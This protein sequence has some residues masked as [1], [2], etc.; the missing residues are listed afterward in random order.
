MRRRW[1]KVLVITVAVLA[2]LFVAA[3]RVAVHYADQEAA[4][5]AAGKYGYGNSSD[6]HLDVDIDGFPFLTQAM[7]GRLDH[8]T[9]TADRFYLD[10]TTN[11]QG[12][13][14]D[15]DHLRLDLRGVEVTSLAA[16][17]AEA[18][19]A[20]GTLT[21]SYQELSD[22]VTRLA[23]AG[24]RLTVSRAPGSAGQAARIRVTGTAGGQALDATGTLL[25]QGTELTL[26]V[27]G[28]RRAATSWSLPLPFGVGFTAARA[29]DDGVEISLVGHLVTLGSSRFTR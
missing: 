2:V 9:L 15:V 12:G 25:A 3:D 1:V 7:A 16:R 22:V 14:L 13:Y 23:G 4:K 18:N 8:V 26:T 5:L 10:N 11:R 27:P 6:G 20:T 29:A 17:S 19:T 21:L 28:A 24:G